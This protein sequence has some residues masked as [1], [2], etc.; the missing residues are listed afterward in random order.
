MGLIA[1]TQIINEMKAAQ[2]AKIAAQQE[3]PKEEK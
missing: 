3:Q 1:L 2:N